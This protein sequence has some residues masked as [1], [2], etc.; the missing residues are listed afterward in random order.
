MSDLIQDSADEKALSFSVFEEDNPL[1]LINLIDSEKVK[2]ALFRIK[3]ECPV[4]FYADDAEIQ[5][6]AKPTRLVLSLKIAFW[7]EYERAVQKRT[8][9]RVSRW[10]TNLVDRKYFY[11]SI[12]PNNMFMLYIITPPRNYEL[13]QRQA[14]DKSITELLAI[15]DLPNEDADGKPN[16]AVINAKI[17]IHNLME[18]RVKGAIAQRFQIQQHVL[19]QQVPSEDKYYET[20]PIRELERLREKVVDHKAS[21][22]LMI[23]AEEEKAE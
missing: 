5:A 22:K 18:L 3:T 1:S 13:L 12:L 6:K 14:L 2:E 10:L 23:E 7:D 19:S 11:D 9:F 15:L 16:A 8:S 21:Q 17:K 4:M 20:L